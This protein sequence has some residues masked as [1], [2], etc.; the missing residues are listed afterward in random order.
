MEIVRKQAWIKKIGVPSGGNCGA[1]QA[2]MQDFYLE[3]A[4]SL[5]SPL[6]E[7]ADILLLYLHSNMNSQLAMNC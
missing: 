2:R 1:L 3:G 5:H 6:N 7:I 4:Y